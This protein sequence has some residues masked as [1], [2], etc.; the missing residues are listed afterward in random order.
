[1]LTPSIRASVCAAHVSFMRKF[2]NGVFV[3]ALNVRRQALQR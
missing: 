2:A 3:K 1:V